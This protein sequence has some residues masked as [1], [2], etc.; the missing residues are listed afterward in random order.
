MRTPNAHSSPNGEEAPGKG[1]G[2]NSSVTI[3]EHHRASRIDSD[4]AAK[5]R[6]DFEERPRLALISPKNRSFIRQD[7]ALLRRHFS[8]RTVSYEYQDPTSI[9]ML[10]PRTL[11]AVV[12]SDVVLCW[13]GS[14][15]ALIAVA[16]CK[17]LGRKSIVVAG[18]YDSVSVPE[19]KYGL[20][21]RRLVAWIPKFAFMGADL[22]LPVSRSIRQDLASHV[23]IPEKK[24]R[25]VYHGFDYS[26]YSPAGP[27][28]AIVLTVGGAANVRAMLRKGL[29]R[30]VDVA[31]LLPSLRF[32][33]VGPLSRECLSLLEQRAFR[34]VSFLGFLTPSQLLSEMRRS[35]VYVQLS[36]HEGFGCSL[37]ESMACGCVPIVA[38]T[39]ALPEVVGGAGFVVN[40]ENPAETAR[41]IEKAIH[42]HQALSPIART[43]ILRTFPLTLREHGL[44]EAVGSLAVDGK[45]W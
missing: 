19:I 21:Y 36:R 13:F 26:R 40:P 33:V 38:A 8:L 42:E 9:A 12:H 44:L 1:T 35:M 43:R 16:L 22:V 29:D 31:R 24:I 7:E 37:A 30:F 15:H 18:G 23:T 28:E 17:L 14:F 34:N 45:R 39:G 10:V 11:V 6:S 32:E 3:P 25:L 2:S 4:T 5:D 27:K 20:F 41:A